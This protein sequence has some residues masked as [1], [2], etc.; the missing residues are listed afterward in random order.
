[1]APDFRVFD[2]LCRHR[3]PFVVIGGHAVNFHGSIR[4][5]EDTDVVWLR[6]PTA[7]AALLAALREIEAAYIG[8]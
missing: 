8:S 5:T 6:S 3:V 1:M 7:E 2:V 4:A